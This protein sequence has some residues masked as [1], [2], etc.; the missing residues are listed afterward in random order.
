[1]PSGSKAID[2]V[3]EPPDGKPDG[4]MFILY[5][6]RAKMPDNEENASVMDTAETEAEAKAAG[7]GTWADHDAI[8]YEYD[9]YNRRPLGVP[10]ESKGPWLLN[11][12]QRWDLPPA[13]DLEGGVDRRGRPRDK[14]K[15]QSKRGGKRRRGRA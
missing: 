5:D 9:V 6:G 7:L 3:I 14:R 2:R 10:R 4:V 11:G 15:L 1:M 8:W 13:K 12:R